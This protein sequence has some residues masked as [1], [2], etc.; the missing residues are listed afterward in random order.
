MNGFSGDNIPTKCC[1]CGMVN[2]ADLWHDPLE[3][4]VTL[5][6]HGCCPSCQEQ[7]M[8]DLG[9]VFS[10]GRVVRRGAESPARSGI[11][12]RAARDIADLAV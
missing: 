12:R 4:D 5:Y 11:P 3:G 1:Y 6:S 7:M 2:S 9:F 8:A 10:D